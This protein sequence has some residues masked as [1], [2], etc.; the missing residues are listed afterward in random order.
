[1][2][3]GHNPITGRT[4][5]HTGEQCGW[6]CPYHHADYIA[7][8]VTGRRSI[9]DPD[10][11]GGSGDASG[12]GVQLGPVTGANF[13]FGLV[14]FIS[15]LA[16]FAWFNGSGGGPRWP[17]QSDWAYAAG[18]GFVA[19][20]FYRLILGLLAL[21]TG[22]LIVALLAGCCLLG[23]YYFKEPALVT[24][25]AGAAA[26]DAKSTI[27]QAFIHLLSKGNRPAKPPATAT[28]SGGPASLQQPG[29]S[30]PHQ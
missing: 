5:S 19:A 28:A 27:H 10:S 15:V 21:A 8:E 12:S 18:A 7:G 30:P 13:A 9:L 11:H 25:W 2:H 3:Y 6:R 22:L 24:A 14:I 4:E 23:Y 29:A 20:L 16:A 1:M 26:A 17:I